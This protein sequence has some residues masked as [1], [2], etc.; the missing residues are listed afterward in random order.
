VPLMSAFYFLWYLYWPVQIAV[1]A[2]RISRPLFIA[3]LAAMVLMFTAGLWMIHL[4]GV[5]G[6][7][8]GQL[9]N[10]LV[11]TV[12]LW[13]AWIREVKNTSSGK[14]DDQVFLQDEE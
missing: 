1:K 11:I 6:T 10:A 13:E 7:I 12:I 4:W 9:L 2:A 5:Y 3:N 14:A 8:A